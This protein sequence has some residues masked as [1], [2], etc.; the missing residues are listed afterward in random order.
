MS[1]RWEVDLGDKGVERED[2]KGM[3]GTRENW[4][5]RDMHY[6]YGKSIGLAA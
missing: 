5:V 3:M 2:L 1:I 4:K 6:G